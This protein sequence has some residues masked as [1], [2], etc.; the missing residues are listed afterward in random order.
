MTVKQREL[1]LKYIALYKREGIEIGDSCDVCRA[2]IGIKELAFY[3]RG[4]YPEKISNEAG[5]RP[6][7]C[8]DHGRELGV[9][10]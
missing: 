2:D 5:C 1:M 8:P 9:V 7:L 3:I 6:N 4:V 10:W